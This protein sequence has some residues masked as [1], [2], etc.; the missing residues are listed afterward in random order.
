M[1]APTQPRTVQPKRKFSAQIA[2][3]FLCLAVL[4]VIPGTKYTN[5]A[6]ISSSVAKTKLLQLENDPCME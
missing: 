3:E 6:T 2:E 4:A 1:N 5:T